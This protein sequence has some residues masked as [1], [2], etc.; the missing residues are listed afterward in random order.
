M[1]VNVLEEF[2]KC[3]EDPI[4]F[5]SN[6]IK[7]THPVR[8][9]VP[10]KLYPFQ[11]KIVKEIQS[12]RFNIL[13]KFRQAG[14]TTIS[15]AYSLWLTIFQKHQSVVILSMGDTE[16][17][18]VLDRIK[19]MYTELP[20][21]LKPEITESNKHTLKLTNGSTIKSRPSG[22]QSGRSLAGSFLIIDEAAF[23]ESIGTIWAAVY[24][25]ISTG[26]RAL[27]LSTVNGLGN[28]YYETYT[29]AVE[30]GN[31]FNAID[32]HWKEHP[33]YFRH[34]DYS[35]LY[36]EMER[37]DP[38]INI[39]NWEKITKANMSQKKWLQEFECQFL[40]TGD[41][42]ID[43]S[44]L[45][46][47]A[48]NIEREFHTKYN[49]RMRVWKE[50]E[51]HYEYVIGVDTALGR[52]L[53]YSAAQI[54]NTYNGEVVAEFYSNKT[55]I[56]EF[57]AIL[58]SEGLYYNVANIIIERNT[59]GNHLIDVLYNNLEYENVWHDAK[60][61]PGFQTTVG[62]RDKLLAELEES[63][64]TNILK[65][66]S[67]RTLNELNTFVI[68]ESGRINADRGKHD[69][70]IMSLALGNMILREMRESTI[71]EFKKETAFK[72][73]KQ[74][75]NKFKMPIITT[76]GKKAEDLEWLIR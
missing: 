54:V 65:I 17:T 38:P 69:D 1:E 76:S 57:G 56:N 47:L 10:F 49:N 40:G 39:D 48:E 34:P 24:P 63:I 20:V 11:N 45:S 12:H 23:I 58:N 33:E 42:F 4:Y 74:Y 72:E 59:I 71:M 13:R 27:V 6:Y 8:G 16:A 64:R 62:N 68:T 3:K 22:K 43:G 26:G 36:E 60:G 51:P 25:I 31:A 70:L 67:E 5:I 44:V 41:T 53:D 28:W 35:A 19:I 32:I 46:Y 7:V 15:A 50:P 37:R 30:K 21:F 52:D 55:P 14:C 2:K 61:N 73:D 66:N 29:K 75:P 18:E 9:L